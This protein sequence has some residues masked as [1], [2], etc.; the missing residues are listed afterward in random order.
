MKKASKAIKTKKKASKTVKAR[1]KG[2]AKAK[3]RPVM[4]SPSQ[5]APTSWSNQDEKR[6]QDGQGSDSNSEFESASSA[7]RNALNNSNDNDG[8]DDDDDD[9]YDNYGDDEVVKAVMVEAVPV[10]DG[11]VD[12]AELVEA[13]VVKAEAIESDEKTNWQH[14]TNVKPI[15]D[16]KKWPSG[17][18][19]K[20]PPRKHVVG[21][22]NPNHH[23]CGKVRFSG[24]GGR[25][26][27]KRI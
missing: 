6:L 3:G 11:D 23:G 8:D 16:T 24:G 22:R 13:M 18:I 15:D 17:R 19:V 21:L 2:E 4:M 7:A 27:E 12:N 26:K 1:K 20:I 5:P 14:T 10:L 9:N 25:R